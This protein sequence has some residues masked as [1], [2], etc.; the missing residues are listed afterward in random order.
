MAIC[1]I[2]QAFPF[3]A[4][5]KNY[6]TLD[7]WSDTIP[8]GNPDPSGPSGPKTNRTFFREKIQILAFAMKITA[9]APKW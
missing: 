7:L 4:L 8:S 6:S 9:F 3:Q 2:Y 1:R 5:S